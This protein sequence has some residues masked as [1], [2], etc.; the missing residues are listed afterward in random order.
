M[1][2]TRLFFST[3]QFFPPLDFFHGLLNSDVWIV[4]DHVKFTSRSR[5]SRCRVKTND[6]IEQLQVAVKRPQ[7]KPIYATVIDGM[8]GWKRYFLRAIKMY[9]YDTPFFTEYYPSVI[10]LI[11]SPHV[12]L[13]TLTL[14]STFW[15]S[16]LLGK[17]IQYL[18]TNDLDT[19]RAGRYTRKYPIAKIIPL[20]LERYHASLFNDPFHHPEYPQRTGP[21]EKDLSILDCLF[22]VGADNTRLL[23]VKDERFIKCPS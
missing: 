21:F 22:S 8:Q 3:P 19:A 1:P 11:E 9:Y 14:E 6:G 18:R 20:L 23:L 12:L 5:Q 2:E 15:V 10:Q 16:E 7:N 4:L 17:K 13:E